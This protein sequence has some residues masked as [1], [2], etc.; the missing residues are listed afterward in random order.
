MEQEFRDLPLGLGMA[1]AQNQD[2][3]ERFARLSD[4]E[5][6]AVVAGA[7]AVRSK[8]EMRAYVAHLGNPAE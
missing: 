2:A 8:S 7:H 1:L 6:Q 3:M 5:K 4:A